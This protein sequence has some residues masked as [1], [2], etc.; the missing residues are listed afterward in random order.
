MVAKGSTM[1]A[2]SRRKMSQ[3]AKKRPSNRLGIKHTVET[4]MK[5][6]RVTRERTP[7]G[8]ALHSYKD[9]K[10]AE[11]R[12]QR[13]SREYK[14][15]R[16]DV[17]ARDK[18]ACQECGDKRGGNLVAHHIKPFAEYPELRFE[19]SNGVTLCRKCHKATHQKTP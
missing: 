17:F 14:R 12:G 9:G 6:S 1:S 7:R 16:F 5:I 11:R 13:F 19:V 10:L 2:E 3:A 18:F 4:R 8:K 15:W